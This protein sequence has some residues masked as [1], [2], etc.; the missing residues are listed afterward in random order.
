MGPPSTL[1]RKVLWSEWRFWRSTQRVGI[2]ERMLEGFFYI[3]I[4]IYIDIFCTIWTHNLKVNSP[5]QDLSQ[6]KKRVIW[7]LGILGRCI[8][9]LKSASK[10]KTKGQ[11]M[12]QHCWNTTELCGDYFINHF[13]D[14]VFLNQYVSISWFQPEA[15]LFCGVFLSFFHDSRM[16]LETFS[17][18]LRKS[19]YHGNPKE[20]PTPPA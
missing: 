6:L 14:P 8:N 17:G 15:F 3:Y 18:H 11:N 19:F 5:K 13:M 10:N 16:D 12:D 7:V 9:A 2:P 20:P 4:Y 1:S